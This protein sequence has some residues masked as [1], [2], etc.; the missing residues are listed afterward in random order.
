[1]KNYDPKTA[2]KVWDRVQ[3][4]AVPPGDSQLILNLIA[5]EILDSR[6]YLQLA[7]RLPP[8]QAAIVRQLAQ[9]EQAHATCLKGIYTM[10]TGR[11]P[12]V[13]PVQGTD[14]P[15]DIVLRRCYGREMRALAQYESRQNDPQYGH[16]FRTLARQ[17]QEHCHRILELLG[18]LAK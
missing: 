3:N 8:P 1:M 5:E 11:N 4:T 10:I 9:Q 2:A 15:A 12:I 14:D 6:T 18:T 16:I 17:E 13:P 7:K